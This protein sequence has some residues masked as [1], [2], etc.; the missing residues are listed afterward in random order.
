ME[1]S[2][3]EYVS[4]DF[5]GLSNQKNMIYRA[6]GLEVGEC[7]SCGLAFVNPRPSWEAMLAHYKS[8]YG[9]EETKDRCNR[10][11]LL[12]IHRADIKRIKKYM[13][14]KDAVVLDVGCGRGLFLHALKCAGAKQLCGIE[15]G[16]NRAKLART[17][18]PN[19]EILEESYETVCIKN[20]SFDLVSAI[21]I[22]EHVYS[23][24]KFFSF[25]QRVLKSGG[26]LYIKT[27]NWGAAKKYN[28]SWKGL[29]RDYEHVYYFDQFT[30][31][32][33]LHKYGFEPIAVDYEPASDGLGNTWKKLSAAKEKDSLNSN[34]QKHS[35]TSL[36]SKIRQMISGIPLVSKVLWWY[37]WKC[38]YYWN[39][40]DIKEGFAQELIMF[41]QKV[42]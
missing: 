9:K 18:L 4:C 8:S 33:Y 6:V 20:N 29:Q 1:Q 5:C 40:R 12:D 41:A 14:L 23:P 26:F 22:I 32:K 42:K 16:S 28:I 31:I 27:P 10:H 7:D 36:L 39:Y 17:I 35:K 25:V 21:D 15:L 34:L 30:L 11:L 3:L 19:V 2:Q 24:R 38:R 37:Y 13:D